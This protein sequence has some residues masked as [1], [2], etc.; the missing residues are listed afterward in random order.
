MLGI[1]MV[2]V[3]ESPVTLDWS[4]L[5]G[6]GHTLY[7]C[8]VHDG[9]WSDNKLLP[10]VSGASSNARI[11]ID[12]A[13]PTAPQYNCVGVTEK[14]SECDPGTIIG[15][16]AKLSTSGWTVDPSLGIWQRPAGGKTTQ[17][18]LEDT[19]D[20]NSNGDDGLVRLKKADRLPDANWECGSF[21]HDWQ[22][23]TL[24]YKPSSTVNP[25]N[26][27]IAP[28]TT[29]MVND[30]I[31]E[32]INQDHFEIR[33]LRLRFSSALI[34]A[35]NAQDV[36]VEN[37][38]LRWASETAI[39]VREASHDGRI[40]N[41]RIHDVG[42]GIYT[43]AL[44]NSQNNDRWVISGNEIFDIDQECYYCDSDSHAI[45]VQ[46]GDDLL[47]E[48][49]HIHHG[50]GSGITFYTYVQQRQMNN[51]VQYNYVHDIKDLGQGNR[52]QRGIEHGN[53]NDEDPETTLNNLVQY[54]VLANIENIAFRAK[55]AKPATPGEFT[56]SFLNNVVYEV[57]TSFEFNEYPLGD[58]GVQIRNNIFMNP[59][60]SYF[61]HVAH[62]TG[63]N[64]DGM[65]ITNNLYYSAV[66][67]TG[68]YS[69]GDGP[70]IFDTL[71]AWQNQS[72][73][74]Q[75]SLESDPEFVD[76]INGAFHWNG[77]VGIIAGAT[78]D[79]AIGASN[80]AAVDAAAYSVGLLNDLDGNPILAGRDIGSYELPADS[81]GD[82]Y[83]DPSDN[84]PNDANP[85]QSDADADGVGNVCDAEQI[86]LY[87]IALQDGWLL[88]SSEESNQGGG[89]SAGDTGPK[90]I[91]F[92]DTYADRQ[93]KGLV[94]FDTSVLSTG[95]D[96]LAA[97][98]ELIRGVFTGNDEPYATFGNAY[99][100]L[101]NG[102]F[103]GDTVTNASD[104]EAAATLPQAGILTDDGTL[105]TAQINAAGLTEIENSTAIQ[106]RI[107]FALDDNDDNSPDQTGYYPTSTNTP[108]SQ[109]PRLVI[110]YTLPD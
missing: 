79:F 99:V 31:I 47:I 75:N 16:S 85:N 19:D 17:Q 3:P 56:W 109:H 69:W 95:I 108:V 71:F 101:S 65:V 81:D 35:V 50:G 62:D 7:V 13:C 73:K 25:P 64:H 21:Y 72:N 70:T 68:L 14:T 41:N 43:E 55:S 54:N 61:S 96:V 6:G 48:H 67:K 87:S 46:G 30:D 34:A 63:S 40:L 20:D 86:T 102:G 23:A 28:H 9:G 45:G 58:P 8:G 52:N 10:N 29:Y 26:C 84:C 1:T 60:D 37:N 24:Y 90:G 12:G 98:L 18:M 77:P 104:F 51:V 105:A 15:A 78:G 42:N 94:G 5:A 33:N 27:D 103:G 76:P 22:A 39:R 83:Y 80:T 4:K 82:G 49:N 110:D 74:G 36:V 38:D 107:G 89:Y 93:F 2:F 100:D 11:I 59:R 44:N 53:S 57:G 97:R 91:R 106:L 66:P 92:G 88:E 32:I